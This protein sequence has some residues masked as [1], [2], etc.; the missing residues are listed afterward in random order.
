MRT[1]NIKGVAAVHE[2][3]STIEGYGETLVLLDAEID[4][5]VLVRPDRDFTELTF[6]GED[7]ETA[8]VTIERA[9]D[10]GDAGLRP[11]TVTWSSSSSRSTGYAASA[12]TAR[13]LMFATDVAQQ[14]TEWAA[15]G[16]LDR[17]N[18]AQAES[19]GRQLADPSREV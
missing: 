5:S 15:R 3:A 14:L 9:E 16:D 18:R 4:A 12:A 13:L 8:S 17:V 10:A 2:V 19:Y 7:V 11:A 1:I 6:R